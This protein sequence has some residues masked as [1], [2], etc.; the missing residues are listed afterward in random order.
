MRAEGAEADRDGGKQRA[1][2]EESLQAGFL[3]FL[4]GRPG[5]FLP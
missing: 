2:G 4:F 5:R 3:V 1:Q